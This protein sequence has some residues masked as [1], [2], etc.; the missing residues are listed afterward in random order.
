MVFVL[1]LKNVC[2][3]VKISDKSAFFSKSCDRYV[4]KIFEKCWAVGRSENPEGDL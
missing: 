2:P 4:V 3:D 1:P